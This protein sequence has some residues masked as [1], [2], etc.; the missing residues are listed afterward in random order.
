M[1]IRIAFVGLRHGHIFD[2]MAAVKQHPDLELAGVCEEDEAARN[3]L[4]SREDLTITHGNYETMLRDV[5]CDVVA[6]GDYYTKRGSLVIR[7]LEAGKHVLSDKPVCTSLKELDRIQTLAETKHRVITSQF[8]LRG[9]GALLTVRRLIQA[10]EIGDVVTVAFGGQHPLLPNSRPA[11]Y[12]EP[13]H[14]GGT[15]ND[16]A[17]HAMDLIPWMTGRNFSRVLAARAWN[18]KTPKFP[19]FQDCGQ[20]LL[21]LDNRGSVFGD[22]SYL[23]PD[24]CGFGISQYWRFTIHGTSGII[25][26]SY[27]S[28][29]VLIANHTDKE[30]RQIPCAD[31]IRWPY[32]EDFLTQI[33]EPGKPVELS[34]AAVLK[35]SRLA[36]RTQQAADEN[37]TN[38]PV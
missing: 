30:P 12:F 2:L 29:H 20:L 38:V 15:I 33:R 17:V 8:D 16:I 9:S 5:P 36:L 13:G 35:A 32:L 34:T 19:H 31:N 25:E 3:A 23:A 10:G 24:G 6:I 7:A 28:K 1:S 18:A 11:W 26:T 14:H 27:G 21:E 22:V 4:K 37:K